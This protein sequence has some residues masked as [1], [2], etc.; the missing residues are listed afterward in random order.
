MK[1]LLCLAVMGW[2]TLSVH[3]ADYEKEK[4]K[5]SAE[6]LRCVDQINLVDKQPGLDLQGKN[7]WVDGWYLKGK[8]AYDKQVQMGM[9][10]RDDTQFKNAL[11][12]LLDRVVSYYLGTRQLDK[13]LPYIEFG[14]R[15]CKRLILIQSYLYFQQCRINTL[16]RLGCLDRAHVAVR[17][18]TDEVKRV[19]NVNRASGADKYN[20]SALFAYLTATHQRLLVALEEDELID[21][22]VWSEEY[23]FVQAAYQK[24]PGL[25]KLSI[26]RV[27]HQDDANMQKAFMF[28]SSG[29]L[30]A[31]EKMYF[32]YARLFANLENRESAL[33]ALEKV[34]A[35]H[36][37]NQQVYSSVR[38]SEGQLK[39]SFKLGMFFSGDEAEAQNI[40][41]E[42]YA[43]FLSPRLITFRQTMYPATIYYKLGDLE[44]ARVE[45]AQSYA[46]FAE[47]D[48]EYRKWSPS[49]RWMDNV[50]A[51]ELGMILVDAQIR[52]RSQQWT[53]ALRLYDSHVA[54]SEALRESLPV[55]QRMEFFRSNAR[56]SYLGSVRCL[57]QL[58]RQQPD[59]G[60]MQKI[61]AASER[62]RARQFAEML[63]LSGVSVTQLN[64]AGVQGSLPADGGILS[65]LDCETHYLVV[66][67][68]QQSAKLNFFDKIPDMDHQLMVIR[69][70]L[71]QSQQF[72]QSDLAVLSRL[73]LS[74]LDEELGGCKRL[75]VI[76]DGAWSSLPATILPF[77]NG[78][79]QDGRTISYLPSLSSFQA[80]DAEFTAP[81]AVT[82]GALLVIA[83][84]QYAQEERSKDY[85]RGLLAMRG[86][87]F[88]GY[89]QPLPETRDEAVAIT[90][91]F[92]CDKNTI[93][94]GDQSVESTVK[95]MDLTAYSFIHIATHGVLSGDIPDLKEPALVLGWEKSEDGLLT[96]SEVS[97]LRLNSELTVLSACNT[98]NGTYFRGEGL[99]GIGRAFMLAG[100][101][102]VL[103][104]LWPVD[105]QATK[106]L[107]VRFYAEFS[108][109]ISAEQ[110]LAKAQNQMRNSTVSAGS[111]GADRGLTVIQAG[112]SDSEAVAKTRNYDNPF[113]WSSFI[114]VSRK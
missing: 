35:T 50:D 23:D 9:R 114:L 63:K 104:S 5:F 76:S 112:A 80:A 91:V 70:A 87:D 25:G 61:L 4:N 24:F 75:H 62:L 73:L 111:Q 59:A 81:T 3:A 7:L 38:Y 14:C 2:V 28:N 97:N 103:V 15:E 84:P 48:K 95:S 21:R 82:T 56:V 100:S 16:L 1:L 17:E 44:R 12:A 40:K 83:D 85:G 11:G 57:T 71:A 34:M 108:Q 68:G 94:V 31:D 10:F 53:E 47:L 54:K 102:Q 30:L 45:I 96:A 79:L 98:G 29:I 41:K 99:I 105:S 106:D 52:E 77:G 18:S 113:Y 69:N 43:R 26:E 55:D 64:V 101:R 58:Y 92:A 32:D 22:G 51:E 88:L 74:G 89:F 65:V 93:L 33:S 39:V 13:A 107:M 46:A 8:E 20:A 110:A 86:G 49:Y 109:G 78:L 27:F 66:Y 36:R 37:Y 19:Y 6:T 60:N 72:Q 67:L 90:N 42:V